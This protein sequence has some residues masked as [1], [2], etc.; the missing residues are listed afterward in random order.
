MTLKTTV[1][2]FSRPLPPAAS[3]FQI[4]TIYQCDSAIVLCT[5]RGK[6]SGVNEEAADGQYGGGILLKYAGEPDYGFVPGQLYGC[7]IFSNVKPWNGKIEL[8]NS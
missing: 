8:S 4:G 3:G 6:K 2:Q 7:G 1:T 5:W